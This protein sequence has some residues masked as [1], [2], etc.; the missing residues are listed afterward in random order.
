M[1][2]LNEWNQERREIHRPVE[3][4]HPNGIACENCGGE[5]EDTDAM[6][7]TSNPPKRN[8]RCPSCGRVG[9][10]VA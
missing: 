10:R 6:L 9:Y 5:L 3:Y 8:I 7:L 1:K 2:T 4:P